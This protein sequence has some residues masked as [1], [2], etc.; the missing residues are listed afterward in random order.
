MPPAPDPNNHSGGDN[1]PIIRAGYRVTL[2]A[3]GM[4]AMTDR[5]CTTIPTLRSTGAK[6]VLLRS[7]IFLLTVL[8]CADVAAAM[9]TLL[10]RAV[11]VS[12]GMDDAESDLLDG[13]F[14]TNSTDLE[15]P[16]E[17]AEQQIVGLR[18]RN[19]DIP[20]GAMI[21]DARIVFTVDSVAN[22]TSFGYDAPID[23][24]IV[25]E[26]LAG[27]RAF[28]SATNQPEDRLANA[29]ATTVDWETAEFPGVGETLTTASVAPILTELLQDS[30]WPENG[31]VDVVFLL[32]QDPEPTAGA[33][34]SREVEAYDGNGTAT[35]PRLEFSY[36]VTVVPLPPSLVL[37]VAAVPLMLRRI[38][39]R[40]G[41]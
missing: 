12:S 38:R 9:Q 16:R 34:G 13:G 26:S 23:L 21:F 8:S 18:F 15:L 6:A 35:A 20:A 33:T 27:S 10:F 40:S 22:A 25:G 30:A 7:I 3:N 28:F 5:M 29:T 17:L 2:H 41:H 36:I 4:P 37:I 32:L 24:I 31:G 19:L 1:E 14:N 39:R 11:S